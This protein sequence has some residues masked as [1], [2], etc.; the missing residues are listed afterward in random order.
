M[1]ES[2]RSK[3]TQRDNATG[4]FIVVSAASVVVTIIFVLIG[5]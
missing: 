1:I 3:E 2:D 4:S 5:L